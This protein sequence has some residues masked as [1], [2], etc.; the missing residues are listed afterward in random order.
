MMNNSFSQAVTVLL[1]PTNLAG[2]LTPSCGGNMPSG[3]SCIFSPSTF[4]SVK[5]QPVSFIVFFAAN[6]VNGATAGSYA[7]ITINVDATINGTHIAHNI[8]LTQLNIMTPGAS[9]TIASTLAAVNSVTNAPLTNVGDPNLT[10]TT[11]V[12]NSGSTYTAA[13]WQ[14]NFS[15]PVILVTSS[16]LSCSQVLPT[17][18]SCNIGDVPVINGNHYS[19]NVIPLFERSVGITSVVTSPTV[20]SINLTGN[21]A[22]APTVQIRLRPLVRKGLVPKAP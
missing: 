13:V 3:V 21:S 6:A 5:G 18:I 7:G 9:T 1:T 11:S 12:D 14:I 22:T 2:V 10:I 16:N 4:V 20:G 19:F 8:P 15:N 17:A